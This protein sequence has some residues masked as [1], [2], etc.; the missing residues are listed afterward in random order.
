MDYDVKD[1]IIVSPGKFEGEPEYTPYF[2]GMVLDGAG[3]YF[4]DEYEN[5]YAYLEI[6]QEDISL[7]PKLE[8]K[9]YIILFEDHIGFVYHDFSDTEPEDSGSQE[10]SD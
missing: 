6:E 1:G 2:W 4:Y 3:T 10:E 5:L 8:G 9:K 7:Y